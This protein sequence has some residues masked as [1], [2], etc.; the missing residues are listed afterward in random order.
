MANGEIHDAMQSVNE[1]RK[2]LETRLDDCIT[3][4]KA[5]KLV[6]AAVSKLHPV[7]RKAVLPSTEEEV[8]ERAAAFKYSPRNVPEKNFTSEYGKKFGNM[9][10]FIMA[11]RDRVVGGQKATNTEGTPAY[12][13]Y[14]VPTDF[15]SELI[16]LL[17]EESPIMRMARVLPM[18]TWKR[19][20]PRQLT[21][22]SV[23]WV[24]EGGTKS[25]TNPT[26]GQVSQEAKVL[27]AVVKCTDELLCDSAINL[28]AFLTEIIGYI[29]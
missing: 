15:Y 9:R 18:S 19:L 5:E 16:K 28:T 26:F 1:L 10:G 3:R 13:G 6:E 24:S 22:I 4:D 29:S 11:I 25:K 7:E 17:P 23:G 14:L 20:I 2:T 12:G 8:M 21:N 27:A